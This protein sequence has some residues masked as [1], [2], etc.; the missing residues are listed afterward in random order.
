MVCV[1][2]LMMGVEF[3]IEVIVLVIDWVVGWD[4]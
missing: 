1:V 2:F 4:W 3:M